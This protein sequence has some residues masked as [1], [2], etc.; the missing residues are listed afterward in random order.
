LSPPEAVTNATE[1][2]LD[3]QDAIAIWVDECCL[4]DPNAFTLVGELYAAWEMWAEAMGEFRS[5][6]KRFSQRLEAM[7]FTRDNQRHRGGRGFR[8]IKGP[9]VNPNRSRGTF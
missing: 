2:Y 7:G 9:L 5:N 6:S 8:G 1:A 4:R 3:D